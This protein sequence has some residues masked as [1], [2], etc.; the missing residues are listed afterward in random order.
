MSGLN[1]DQIKNT[2]NQCLVIIA[3]SLDNESFI[4]QYAP[5]IITLMKKVLNNYKI[6]YL[7]QH[8]RLI[9]MLQK[10]LFSDRYIDKVQMISQII[11][12]HLSRMTGARATSVN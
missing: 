5:M 8:Q 6:K 10:T 12:N 9:K 4:T 1:Y 7:G 11:I 2:L 3:F